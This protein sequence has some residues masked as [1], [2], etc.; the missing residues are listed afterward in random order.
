ML[1]LGSKVGTAFGS[2]T[3]PTMRATPPTKELRTDSHVGKAEVC[4]PKVEGTLT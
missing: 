1:L 3:L 2:P 4:A